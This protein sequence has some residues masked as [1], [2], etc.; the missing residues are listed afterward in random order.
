MSAPV[1]LGIWDGHDSGAACLVD[2][3]VTAAVNEERL[4]RRKL[5][6]AFPDRA[7]ALC[8]AQSGVAARDVSIVAA[9][10]TDVAKTLE[11]LMPWS[12]ERYYQVRRR[13]VPPGPFTSA[14]R[15]LKRRLTPWPPNAP[16]R[17]ASRRLLA[18]RLSRLG[19]STAALELFDHHECHAIAAAHTS[20]FAD[21]AV[22]TID[23]LGDG[24]SSTISRF[25]D[26]RLETLVTSP[27]ADSL[28]VFFEH[29]TGMM[30]M[31]ELEDEGK[32]MALA[33]YSAPVD[34]RDNPLL[35]LF[36]VA[37]GRVRMRTDALAVLARVHWANPNERFARL[38][39]RLV[40]V[41]A[42]A[43][44]R[45]AVRLSGCRRVALAGG[46][47]SNVKA[48]RVIRLLPEVEDVYV[49]P[50]MGDGG[51]PV[52]AAIAAHARRSPAQP[53]ALDPRSI[54]PSFTRDAMLTALEGVGLAVTE[55]VDPAS[56]V[57]ARIAAGQIVCWF[58]GPM[59]YGPRA[60]GHRSILAGADSLQV[61]DRLNLVLKRRVWYQPFCPAVLESDAARLFSDWPSAGHASRF[62]TMA[63]MVADEYRHALAG[64]VNVDGSCRPQLVADDEPSPLARL[65]HAV[66]RHT[67]IGAV[68]N[69]SFNIHGEPLVHTPAQA[70]D[71]FLRGG[72]DALRLGPFLVEPAKGGA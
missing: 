29:V 9:S 45:D 71:V 36:D 72:A 30:N 41:V 22:L 47:A 19:L 69:T 48:N 70:V 43:L 16:S 13:Q 3:R 42:T 68:L 18:R 14:T 37:N 34:D 50:H 46:V 56:A 39:Q 66:R 44:A 49:F 64:V 23:G 32:V 59:E 26:G 51:L 1:I 57:A 27:A 52:G 35:T 61:K 6:V 40:E 67:G 17:A 28:G 12:K 31:R 24:L 10:T 20:G 5:E 65:L 60:L 2:G 33:D 54:G 21:C 38:S 53:V 62:M 55:P 7:I 11:R 4:T 25:R 58:E 63:Y 15:W 8:L